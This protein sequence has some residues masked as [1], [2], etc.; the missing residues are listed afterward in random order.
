MCPTPACQDWRSGTSC[1]V[2]TKGRPKQPAAAPQPAKQLGLRAQD[3]TLVKAQGMPVDLTGP[4]SDTSATN[5]STAAAASSA[6]GSGDLDM[7]QAPLTTAPPTP[8]HEKKAKYL[9]SLKKGLQVAKDEA[10]PAEKV[11]SLE[12]EIA[13]LDT[14]LSKMQFKSQK[15]I[16]DAKVS[17][18]TRFCKENK[19]RVAKR[20]KH[21]E[22][23]EATR[24]KRGKSESRK[25]RQGTRRRSSS[26]RRTSTNS[27][28]R[29]PNS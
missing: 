15:D 21:L 29:Q 19:V 1:Q 22:E 4:D 24:K 3:Q 25:R 8:D 6:D 13:E 7:Q 2:C 28:Q 26:F 23:Q 10:Y 9:V 27:M 17:H 12:K 18:N 14:E 5:A 11:S 16:A 20:D